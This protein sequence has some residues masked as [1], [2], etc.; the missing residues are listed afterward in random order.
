MTNKPKILMFDLG[1]VINPWVGIEALMSCSGLTR[2]GVADRF[3]TSEFG[4]AFERGQA[5]EA[6]FIAE[7]E[8]MWDLPDTDKIALWNSWVLPPYP[9]TLKALADLKTGFTTA[10]LSNTNALHWAHLKTMYDLNEAFH[11]PF[12]S[13]LLHEAKPDA[14]CYLKAL[15]LMNCAA[16]DVWFFDDT[17]ANIQAAQA[18]GITAFH[19]D[20]AVGVLP[21]LRHLDL[22]N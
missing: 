15:E 2:E 12:A 10:C 9:G 22:L 11:H 19:V 16:E 14:S 13:H 21:M 4:G 8:A 6:E 18:L 17:E 7:F 1:G 5:S 20:R 3:A